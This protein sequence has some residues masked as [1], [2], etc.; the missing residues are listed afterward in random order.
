MFS[1]CQLKQDKNIRN[2]HVFLVNDY[3]I[4]LIKQLKIYHVDMHIKNMSVHCI[5]TRYY[6]EKV[7]NDL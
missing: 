6:D 5:T 3:G 2:N 7:E 4:H 1:K